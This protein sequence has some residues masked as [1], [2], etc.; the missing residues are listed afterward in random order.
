MLR[1][2]IAD[3]VSNAIKSAS[4]GKIS[5]LAPR[6]QDW[7]RIAMND[8]GT[9]IDDEKLPVLFEAFK[10]SEEETSS[11]YAEIG[12]GLRVSQRLCEFMGGFRGGCKAARADR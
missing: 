3:L 5:L 1:H 4:D 2:A 10:D 8:N 6:D 12:L 7:L 11:K 9:G